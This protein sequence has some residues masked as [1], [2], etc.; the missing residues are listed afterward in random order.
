MPMVKR[1]LTIGSQ[2]KAYLL[3]K[4]KTIGETCEDNE[5]KIS[6][7]NNLEEEGKL[8]VKRKALQNISN[9]TKN[10]NSGIYEEE[11]KNKS[12][13]PD[14]KGN[15]KQENEKESKC[16]IVN[17]LEKF[18]LVPQYA[19]HIYKYLKKI[20]LERL[21]QKWP[22]NPAVTDKMRRR[23]V[24]WIWSI[25]QKLK[26]TQESVHLSVYLLD[27]SIELLE[28]NES[29]LKLIT[30]CCMSI[31]TKYEEV[32]VHRFHR[33]LTSCNPPNSRI[34][35]RNMEMKILNVLDF[36]IG[37]P[38][39]L[40]FLRRINMIIRSNRIQHTFG[41]F[42][43]DMILFEEIFCHE[44][45]S[46]IASAASFI[47]CCLSCSTL[48]VNLWTECLSFD[49]GYNINNLKPTIAQMAQVILNGIKMLDSVKEKYS[50]Q[51]YHCVFQRMV[52]EKKLLKLL[53]NFDS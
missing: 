12:I 19:S 23:A 2:H 47:A 16:E 33:F 11:N 22:T 7:S 38:S 41:K 51:E 44:R 32:A 26:L 3:R 5:N 29:N 46:L 8:G 52:K 53:S 24:D 42:I 39:S 31:A 17:C 9:V 30:L 13:Q 50:K 6:N 20:E 36:G 43:I 37:R 4:S 28:V 21:C 34:D 10:V 1:R 48:D 27:K 49:T 40:H 18:F 15:M 35:F 14:I 25:S 45:P